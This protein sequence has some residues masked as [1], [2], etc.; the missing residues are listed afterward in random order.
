MTLVLC[1]CTSLNKTI[2]SNDYSGFTSCND[3]MCSINIPDIDSSI[4]Y[5]CSLNDGIMYSDSYQGNL[6]GYK[7]HKSSTK[8][9][10]VLYKESDF[11]DKK[12]NFHSKL[13]IDTD[14]YI[15]INYDSSPFKK[16]INDCRISSHN[17]KKELADI[18]NKK[19]V[20]AA[21]K[22]QYQW[23]SLVKKYNAKGYDDYP[24]SVFQFITTN[25]YLNK[26]NFLFNLNGFGHYK[27]S[28]Q[29]KHGEVMAVSIVYDIRKRSMPLIIKS[30]QA[31][32]DGSL[33][34]IDEIIVVYEGTRNYIDL[35]GVQRQ[36]AVFRVTNEKL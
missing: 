13:G 5:R 11:I 30:N 18:A 35:Y 34:S 19:K 3:G 16:A 1:G 17:Y 31:L 32:Y 25:S 33:M 27:V 26:K 28:Q 10:L 4:T 15:N 9:T 14:D 20:E 22:K 23:E 21:K 36:A 8:N 7:P 24:L 6:D 2:L 12:T 29:L